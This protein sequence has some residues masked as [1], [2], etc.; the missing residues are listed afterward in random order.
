MWGFKNI[1]MTNSTPLTNL[2]L[3]LLLD[4]TWYK[5]YGIVRTK[6]DEEAMKQL[7]DVG[8]VFEAKYNG[9]TYYMN[10]Y[11]NNPAKPFVKDPTLKPTI[12]STIE[13]KTVWN[14]S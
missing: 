1:V 4:N 10:N 7:V 6:Q 5:E 14:N 11:S 8:L 9:E 2:L 3:R 12:I 13:L